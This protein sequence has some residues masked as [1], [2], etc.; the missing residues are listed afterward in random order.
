MVPEAADVDKMLQ[1][2]FYV[3]S[4]LLPEGLKREAAFEAE[5]QHRRYGSNDLYTY[6]TG[7]LPDRNAQL[8]VVERNRRMSQ[9]G[10]R[11]RKRNELVAAWKRK[12]SERDIGR[13]EG[14]R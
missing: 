10:L 7:I 4:C 8:T 11:R 9:A 2:A 14:R 1:G 3:E 5:Y 12:R 6:N 13:R